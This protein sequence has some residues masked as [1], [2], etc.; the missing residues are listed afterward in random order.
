MF[1][2]HFYLGRVRSAA[3]LE[4]LTNVA[5]YLDNNKF[6]CTLSVVEGAAMFDICPHDPAA[7]QRYD[8]P[9]K[10]RLYA[11]ELT[12]HALAKELAHNDT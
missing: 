9:E 11:A 2:V 6:S 3:H 10:F 5:A 12:M 1:D 4:R 8:S 7:A